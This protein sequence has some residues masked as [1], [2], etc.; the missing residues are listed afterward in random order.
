MNRDLHTWVK[1]L[2]PK[3]VLDVRL[4]MPRPYTDVHG[5]RGG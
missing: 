2:I 1:N 5:N 3:N 4:L